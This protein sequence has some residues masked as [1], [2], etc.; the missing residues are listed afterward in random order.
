ME[1]KPI[2]VLAGVSQVSFILGSASASFDCIFWD[3]KFKSELVDTC[4]FMPVTD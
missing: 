3:F 4:Q 1:W 2:S